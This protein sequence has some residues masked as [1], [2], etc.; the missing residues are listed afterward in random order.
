MGKNFNKGKGGGGLAK[1]HPGFSNDR[2]MQ[3]N[4]FTQNFSDNDPMAID[5]KRPQ[6][7]AR[8]CNRIVREMIRGNIN[9]DSCFKYIADIRYLKALSNFAYT[10]GLE[11]EMILGSIDCYIANYNTSNSTDINN[12]MLNCSPFYRAA[13]TGYDQ[14]MVSNMQYIQMQNQAIYDAAMAQVQ[15]SQQAAISY[16]PYVCTDIYGNQVMYQMP[17]QQA[18]VQ[19]TNIPDQAINSARAVIELGNPVQ[20]LPAPQPGFGTV[21]PEE[22]IEILTKLRKKQKDLT[23]MY[24]IILNGLD[25]FS[26]CGGLSSAPLIEMGNNLTPY[27]RYSDY[28]S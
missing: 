10:K 23:N 15:Q 13:S 18:P 17:V 20:S 16:V 9:Y 22:Y 4:Y 1:K 14:Y 3:N 27:S 6:E 2:R 19:Q 24:R 26:R 21:M 7:I 8:D 12:Q 25:N 11:A 28:I 5:R